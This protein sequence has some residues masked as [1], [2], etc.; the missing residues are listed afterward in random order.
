MSGGKPAVCNRVSGRRSAPSSLRAANVTVARPG[1]H[2]ARVQSQSTS[3][4]HPVS[5]RTRLSSHR[6][7]LLQCSSG[8]SRLAPIPAPLQPRARCALRYVAICLRRLAGGCTGRSLGRRAESTRCCLLRRTSHDLPPAACRAC[9][10]RSHRAGCERRDP[11]L[12]RAAIVRSTRVSIVVAVLCA[13]PNIPR[14]VI[15]P[16]RMGPAAGA[17]R[18]LILRLCEQAVALMGLLPHPLCIFCRLA[19]AHTGHRIAVRLRKTRVL[20]VV[21]ASGHVAVL[22]GALG[23]RTGARVSSWAAHRA[24]DR[25]AAECAVEARAGGTLRA[26]PACAAPSPQAPDRSAPPETSRGWRG[27]SGARHPLGP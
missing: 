19:A 23:K 4:S 9:R 20:P 5:Y 7:M 10:A 24:R 3:A 22:C 21:A 1:A 26:R 17:I 16:E 8:P 2:A 14:H 12:P 13:G 25:T 27:G 11:H 18:D 15:Q 6:R